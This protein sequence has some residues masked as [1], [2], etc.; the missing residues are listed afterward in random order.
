MSIEATIISLVLMGVFLI[1]SAF[2]SSSETAFMSLQ[3][4]RI[5]HLANIGHPGAKRMSSRMD[6]PEKTLSTVLLGNNLVNTAMAAVGTALAIAWLDRGVA[7][8]ASTAGVTVLL[9]ILGEVVPKTF[10]SRHAESLAFRYL[11]P[12]TIIE[13][14]LF[15]FATLVRWIGTAVVNLTGGG[16]RTRY[17]VSEE[18]LRSVISIGQREGAVEQEEAKM[19]HKVLSFG[20]RRVKEVMTPRTEIA[21][22]EEDTTLSDFLDIYDRGSRS[23]FPMYK[24][25]MDNVVGILH[26]S[27]VI[28]AM[29][30]G[31]I[32]AESDLVHLVRP[33]RF[34]PETKQLDDLFEEM[35]DAGNQMSL[36]VDEHGGIAGLVTTQQLVEAITGWAG[37]DEEDAAEEVESLGQGTFQVDGGMQIEEANER[38]GVSIPDGEYETLAGFLLDL[39]GHIPQEGDTAYHGSM[40]MTVSEMAGVKIEK[41][42]VSKRQEVA[43]VESEASE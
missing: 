38:L 8:V 3:R 30:K 24:E 11:R 12:F 20:D 10:A 31:A 32:E 36:A 29:H 2:F 4:I 14:I 33:A 25:T 19:L 9:L 7:V 23:R 43:P 34:V 18:L 28:K 39:L 35:Q 13:V 27:D 37:E 17:L 42:L 26:T 1:F 40:S 22:V 41:I 6:Q 21:W 5:L 15:P 16:A